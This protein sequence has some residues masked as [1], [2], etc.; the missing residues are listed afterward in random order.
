MKREAGGLKFIEVELLFNRKFF[1]KKNKT[2]SIKTSRLQS[3]SS[4]LKKSQKA[5]TLLP[6]LFI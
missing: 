5:R 3:P 4:R 1:H 2:Q 6:V